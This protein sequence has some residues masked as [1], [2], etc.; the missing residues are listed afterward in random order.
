MKIIVTGSTSF[1]GRAAVKIMTQK[2]REVI[3]FRH[4]FEDETER[5]PE[6]ADVWLHF[7]WAGAGSAG[8][9]DP[10]IQEFNIQMTLRAAQKAAELGCGRFLFAGSQAEYGHA[11]D[12]T[13]KREDGPAEPVSEYGRAKLEVCRQLT[14][15]FAARET[16]YIHMRLFSV[17]GPGDHENSLVNTLIRG[18]GRGEEISLG[19]CTQAWNYLYIDEAAE[20]I[21][22]LA[23]R[24]ERGIYNI[25]GEDTRALRDYV[26][27][28][29]RICGGSGTALFGT[30]ADN[31][32]GPADLSPDIS[33][34]EALGFRQRISF[35]DGIGR[36]M[37][38]CRL[39]EAN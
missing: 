22:L 30:R 6:N 1:L 19:N 3:P 16:D 5:L 39:Q 33:R 11:Q 37:E 29:Q 25:A 4:S 34:L 24:G 32:E 7:A 38:A 10:G 23:E 21:D 12:G 35:E 17:Y 15:Y 36:I 27:E 26:E 9:S 31:A 18:F 8:R 20:A 28:V 13:P 2:G 14:A